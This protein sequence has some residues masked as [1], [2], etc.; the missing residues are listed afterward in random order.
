MRRIIL[1]FFY[2]LLSCTSPPKLSPE[3]EQISHGLPLGDPEP[4]FYDVKRIGSR[5]T[6]V[7]DGLSG[8]LVND[9]TLWRNE[10]IEAYI[11]SSLLAMYSIPGTSLTIAGGE[12]AMYIVHDG[13][14]W[15]SARKLP[16]EV[17]GHVYAY[18]NLFEAA[19]YKEELIFL[20]PVRDYFIS[21]KNNIWERKKLPTQVS[22]YATALWS[23]EN[24]LFMATHPAKSGARGVSLH[25]FNGES[26][27]SFHFDEKG[28]FNSIEGS[29]LHDVWAVGMKKP[30][31]GKKSLVYHYDGKQWQKI[32]V[33]VDKP[34][35]N[36]ASISPSEAYVVGDEGTILKWDGHQWH[37][38]ASGV[39]KNLFGIHLD[40][41][42]IFVVG[43]NVI[44]K[45]KRGIG[46]N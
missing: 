38:S 24:I 4:V 35:N 3:W 17:V 28:H 5:L 29:S 12:D 39:T 14:Q 27:Q 32:K 18:F 20:A 40:P 41:D 44:L 46:P 33:P 31:F 26:W 34:I 15:T 43:D 7:G 23:T 13:Q 45:Q 8:F 6:I 21:G 9:G 10:N 30:I 16:Q 2:S 25:L 22:S 11:R 37:V 19:S 42:E 1:L 36:V